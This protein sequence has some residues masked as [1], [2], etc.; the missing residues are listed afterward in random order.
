VAHGGIATGKMEPGELLDAHSKAS[1]DGRQEA[2]LLMLR[3][4]TSAKGGRWRLVAACH[5]RNGKKMKRDE[6]AEV[7]DKLKEGY[8][9]CFCNDSETLTRKTA[10]KMLQG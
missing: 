6:T 8:A 3:E 4:L 5:G 9:W 7:G 2:R 10:L 1:S